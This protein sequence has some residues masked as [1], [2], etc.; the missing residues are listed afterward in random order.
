MGRR[1]TWKNEKE[2][3]EEVRKKYREFF[4]SIC[5]LFSGAFKGSN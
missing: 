2:T 4:W 3:V 5:G 1:K